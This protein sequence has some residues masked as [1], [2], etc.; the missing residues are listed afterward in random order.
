MTELFDERIK[1]KGVRK[2]KWL[3]AWDV[4]KLFR[5]SIIRPAGGTYRMNWL[6]VLLNHFKFSLRLFKKEKFYAGLNI[7]GLTLGLMCGIVVLVY[8][9]HEMNYDSHHK[10]KNKIYRLANAISMDGGGCDCAMSAREL[11]EFLMNN[12]SE[13]QGYVRFAPFYEEDNEVLIS[14]LASSGVRKQFYE[15][16]LWRTDSNMFETFTHEF[17]E[18]NPS[19]CLKGRNK[20]VITQSMAHKYFGDKPALG[21]I[22]TVEMVEK[23]S[24]EITA[25]IEDVPDNSHFKF[26]FLVSNVPRRPWVEYAGFSHTIWN[27]D[28]YNYLVLP[29]N[30]DV[31]EM[32]KK[33]ALIFEEHF[34]ETADQIGGT[35]KPVI[36]PLERIHYHSNMKYGES[37]GNYHFVMAF[38]GVAVLLIFMVCTNYVNLSTARALSRSKEIGVRKILGGN[39]RT[40]IVSIL[41]ETYILLLVSF[42]LALIGAYLLFNSDVFIQLLNAHLE[43]NFVEIPTLMWASIGLFTLIGLLA[44]LY[45][46]FFISGM[47]VLKI[48][49]GKF[50]SS[51]SGIWTRKVLI[52]IQFSIALMVMSCTVLMSLQLD[53]IRNK[54][55]GFNM[56]NVLLLKVPNGLDRQKLQMGTTELGRI[57]GVESI[58]YATAA[59]G[60]Y[61]DA[62]V[63]KVEQDTSYVQHEINQ[64]FVGGDYLK[65]MNLKLLSGRSFLQDSKMDELNSFIVNETFVRKMGWEDSPIGKEIRDWRDHKV[66]SVIGVVEDYNYYSLHNA[67]EPIFIRLFRTP[68][69]DEP[70]GDF[71]LRLKNDDVL[72]TIA[73]L[74]ERWGQIYPNELFEVKFLDKTVNAQYEEDRKKGLIF[75]VLSYISI[76][77][78]LLGL[79]GVTAYTASQ[80][81]KEIGL[82][83]V[84]GAEILSIVYLLNKGYVPLILLAMML[85]FPIAHYLV[86]AWLENFAYRISIKWW[87]FLGP[88]LSMLVLTLLVIGRQSWRITLL[89]PVDSLR[90]E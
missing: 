2:A 34:G 39:R 41:S 57:P 80:K 20:M 78:S 87:H 47:P 28:G 11:P 37:N 67:I 84:L 33:F 46:G 51:N 43:L 45:P 54:E 68:D 73:T 7:V 60:Y 56:S 75:S 5:P 88:V 24:F 71:H 58:T 22:L 77:I 40:L 16:R 83:R 32:P 18:G 66:G 90:D 25:V 55:L 30:Y 21:E 31:A 23:E 82:R 6:G 69:E 3:F 59:P 81:T 4:I 44:G 27:P 86:T 61:T 79:I 76:F 29:E 8:L 35:Y 14:H 89:N 64:V 48:A 26:D 70:V 53:F 49:G 36:E 19:T 65:T 52:T 63:F 42:A 74:E 1:E 9:H 72:G 50:G 12:F 15:Q 85:S 62:M 13:V 10:N 38:A 17:I